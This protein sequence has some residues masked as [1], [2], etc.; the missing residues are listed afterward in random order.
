MK[1]FS[2]FAI[3]K[4]I[5]D[6]QKIKIEEILNK[7][8]IVTGALINTSKFKDTKYLRLQIEINNLKYVVFTGSEVLMDQ[9]NKYFEQIPFATQIIKI[10][11][12]Y[13]F[14]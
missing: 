12:Y 9:I 14:S 2:D 10:K 8:L 7:E 11:K 4:P 6:G 1:Q 13:T 5:L 3:E